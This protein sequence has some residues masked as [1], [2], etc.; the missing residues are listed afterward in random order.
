MN[1]VCPCGAAL[2]VDSV[3]PDFA[4]WIACCHAGHRVFLS[5]LDAPGVIWDE[6][7]R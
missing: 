1:D 6:V 2:H 4:G 7:D 3:T 5:D